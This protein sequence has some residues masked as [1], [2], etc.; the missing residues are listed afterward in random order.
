MLVFL[1]LP[2]RQAT[3]AAAT[4]KLY[5]RLWFELEQFNVPLV[6]CGRATQPAALELQLLR[7]RLEVIVLL[8]RCDCT[9]WRTML[10]PEHRLALQATL[11]ALLELV[12]VPLA[13]LERDLIAGAQNW[14]LDAVLSQWRECCA[15]PAPGVRERLAS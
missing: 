7:F 10:S 15:A 8:D 12:D 11:K 6:G 13:A 9:A 5:S 2:I 14:L 3:F 1:H 4:I